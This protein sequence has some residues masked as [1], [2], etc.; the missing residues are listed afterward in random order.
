MS[1]DGPSVTGAPYEPL[2][3]LAE[4]CALTVRQL[5]AE[6]REAWSPGAAARG[7]V[8]RLRD[9]LGVDPEASSTV[10]A[11]QTALAV[12]LA[13]GMPGTPAGRALT[14]RAEQLAAAQNLVL[15]RDAEVRELRR[16]LSQRE[17]GYQVL[18]AGHSRTLGE[19]NAEIARLQAEIDARD[20]RKVHIVPGG[21]A[22]LERLLTGRGGWVPEEGETVRASADGY[23]V[24]WNGAAW[25]AG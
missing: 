8:R 2:A 25:V 22:M 13:S 9:Q 16:L 5:T 24:R 7:I 14:E 21:R 20:D 12:T 15:T 17:D 1:N 3:D 6:P 10:L 4:L 19:K 23:T 18:A 11:W